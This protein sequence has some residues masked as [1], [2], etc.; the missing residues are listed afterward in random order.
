M[1]KKLRDYRI[2]GFFAPVWLWLLGTITRSAAI[3]SYSAAALKNYWTVLRLS[4]SYE[5][6]TMPYILTKYLYQIFSISLE[7]RAVY[8]YL[9]ADIYR[10]TVLEIWLFPEKFWQSQTFPELFR[11]FSGTFPEFPQNLFEIFLEE[12]KKFWA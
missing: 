9:F 11:I 2:L 10:G 8:F 3:A 1:L 6:N 12:M 5:Q 7:A 4:M